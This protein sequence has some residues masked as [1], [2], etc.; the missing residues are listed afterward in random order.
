[1][2]SDAEFKH[3]NIPS[4]GSEAFAGAQI[5][6]EWHVGDYQHL[7]LNWEWIQRHR[8]HCLEI[9][10][11]RSISELPVWVVYQIKIGNYKRNFRLLE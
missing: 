7:D 4:E 1:V 6:L 11:F 9:K 10:S 5:N 8:C 3:G 2:G